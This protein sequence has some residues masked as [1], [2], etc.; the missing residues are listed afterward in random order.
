MSAPTKRKRRGS[1]DLPALFTPPSDNAQSTANNSDFD[2]DR[3]VAGQVDWSVWRAIY[4]GEF[5][6]ACRCRRCGRWLTDGTSKRRH[7]GPTCA[8][9]AVAE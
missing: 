8:A 9:K 3:R 6:L 4:N 1:E 5:R 2:F 7:L